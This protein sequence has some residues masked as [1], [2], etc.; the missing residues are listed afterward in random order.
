PP[1]GLVPPRPGTPA[2]WRKRLVC[3][4]G[5]IFGQAHPERLQERRFGPRRVSVS[6]PLRRNVPGRAGRIACPC[7]CVHRLT[8]E[9]DELRVERETKQSLW[10]RWTTFLA[11]VGLPSAEWFLRKRWGLV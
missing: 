9:T 11:F 4:S 3:N 10:G 8:E 6:Q 7:V 5:G 1:C 2:R